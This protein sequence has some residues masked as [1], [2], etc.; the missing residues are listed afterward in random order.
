[1]EAPW[2]AWDG[3]MFPDY[4]EFPENRA[5]RGRGIQPVTP[6]GDA[7]NGGELVRQLTDFA[8]ARAW[9]CASTTGWWIW[10]PRGPR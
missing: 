2:L 4:Y 8:A 5:V 7:G 10:S 6:E 3:Q 9:R 1:M